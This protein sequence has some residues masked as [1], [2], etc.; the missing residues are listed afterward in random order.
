MASHMGTLSGRLQP[1]ALTPAAVRELVCPVVSVGPP[2][3]P[4]P[5]L[6]LCLPC[7]PVL[8]LETLAVSNM[9]TAAPRCSSATRSGSREYHHRV[10]RQ[11][12]STLE[13]IAGAALNPPDRSGLLQS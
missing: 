6:S 8:R 5:L 12:N 10:V 4:E 7:G 13:T 3:S 11:P 9:T 1:G 2:P